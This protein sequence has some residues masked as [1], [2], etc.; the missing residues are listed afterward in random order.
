[1]PEFG[2]KLPPVVSVDE[3]EV[4]AVPLSVGKSPR[5]AARTDSRLLATEKLWA[6]TS[7]RS[8]IARAIARS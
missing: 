3:V 8:A 7:G 2:R 5:L 6:E 4:E 1:M